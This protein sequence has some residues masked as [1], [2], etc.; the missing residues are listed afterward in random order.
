MDSPFSDCVELSGVSLDWVSRPL[1]TG[2]C[3]P[4]ALSIAD[5]G[6]YTRR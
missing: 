2:Y 1:F 5:F 4:L 3:V 6:R